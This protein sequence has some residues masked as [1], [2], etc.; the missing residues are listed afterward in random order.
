MELRSGILELLVRRISREQESQWCD[1]PWTSFYDANFDI[2]CPAGPSSSSPSSICISR[3][4]G[5]SQYLT[6]GSDGTYRKFFV[7]GVPHSSSKFTKLWRLDK[8]IFPILAISISLTAKDL[9]MSL[10]RRRRTLRFFFGRGWNS[11]MRFICTIPMRKTTLDVLGKSF[12]LK[13]E[14]SG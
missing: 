8:R 13:T 10:F 11:C 7:G 6:P 3:G 5:G 14:S 9:G 12:I 4:R 1:W 2:R